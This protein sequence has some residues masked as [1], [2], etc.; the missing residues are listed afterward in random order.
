MHHGS[1][2]RPAPRAIQ[3]HPKT[4]DQQRHGGS[5][6]TI[7]VH[8]LLRLRHFTIYNAFAMPSFNENWGIHH[9]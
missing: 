9:I 4:A 6:F 3:K 1:L 7:N 8:V 2:G 5:G